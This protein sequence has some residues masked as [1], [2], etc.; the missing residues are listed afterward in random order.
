MAIKMDPIKPRSNL[1]NYK[2]YE[3]KQD[4]ALYK[5]AAVNPKHALRSMFVEEKLSS[6]ERVLRSHMVYTRGSLN[7]S[8]KYRN[9]SLNNSFR[10]PTALTMNDNQ[11]LSILSDYDHPPISQ[12]ATNTFGN[13]FRKNSLHDNFILRSSLHGIN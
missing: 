4:G 5:N 11:R 7:R 12:P 9:S 2:R 6:Q 8:R 13:G 1:D 10:A 3:N